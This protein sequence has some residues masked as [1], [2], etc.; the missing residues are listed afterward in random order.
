MLFS[1]LSP[2]KGGEGFH[3]IN[4]RVALAVMGQVAHLKHTTGSIM[5][6]HR[7]L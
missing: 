4:F 3:D 6:P 7:R 1:S 2:L 5:D